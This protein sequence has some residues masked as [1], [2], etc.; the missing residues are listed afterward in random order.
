M[1]RLAALLLLAMPIP[2]TGQ[3]GGP[4]GPETI[5]AIV[6]RKPVDPRL[7]WLPA[8]TGR[9]LQVDYDGD[10]AMDI[11][12]LVTNGRHAAVRVTS[13]RTGRTSNAWLIDNRLPLASDAFLRRNGRH[14]ISIVFPES[15]EILLFREKGRPMAT[16]QN[17]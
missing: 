3:E 11:A 13:G 14:A 17:G 5:G 7:P 16:Y 15:T 9:P 6:S 12:R 4:E 2:A 8:G 1:I 10:G